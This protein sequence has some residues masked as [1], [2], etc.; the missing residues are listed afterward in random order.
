ML[1]DPVGVKGR[2]RRGKVVKRVP[3]PAYLPA[4]RAKT[5]CD[6][7]D[8]AAKPV[9]RFFPSTGRGSKPVERFPPLTSLPPRLVKRFFALNLLGTQGGQAIFPLDRLGLEGG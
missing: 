9:E 4:T 5:P 8:S 7:T 2:R 3:E 6:L 1:C